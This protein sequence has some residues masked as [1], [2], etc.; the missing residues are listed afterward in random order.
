VGLM[1]GESRAGK[2]FL[3]LNLAQALAKG[4]MFLTKRARVGGT[5]YVAAE[6]P[7]TIPGRLRAA[8]LDRWSRF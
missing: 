3:A 7:G 1:V 8:L 2:T 5:L 4:D 6:A